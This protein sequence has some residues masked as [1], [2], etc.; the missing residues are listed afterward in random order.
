MEKSTNQAGAAEQAAPAFNLKPITAEDAF[1]LMKIINKI[2]INNVSKSIDPETLKRLAWKRP[3]KQ[4]ISKNGTPVTKD[5]PVEEWTDQQIKA[6][7]EYEIAMGQLSVAATMTVV[8][9]FPSCEKEIYQLLAKSMD[10]EESDVRG[11]NGAEFMALLQEYTGRQEFAD[12]F[13]GYLKLFFG[14]AAL[15]A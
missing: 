9:N 3:Q 2:G 1:V 14:K 13:T 7:T 6:E 8:E 10:E 4:E 11:M 5:L 15:R 12:F